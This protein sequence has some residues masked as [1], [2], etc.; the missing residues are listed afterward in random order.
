MRLLQ[1]RMEQLKDQIDYIIEIHGSVQR[2][3]GRFESLNCTGNMKR[4]EEIEDKVDK[5]P[6]R[7]WYFLVSVIT[8]L[9][10]IYG[11]FGSMI[12]G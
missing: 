4:I 7:T 5:I 2:L 12:K 9:I 11:A 6:S 8:L 1:R 10:A 3:E